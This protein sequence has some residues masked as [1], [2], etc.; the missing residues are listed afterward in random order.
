MGYLDKTGLTY[1]WGKIKAYIS[2]LTANDVGAI[3]KPSSASSGQFLVF[4]GTE[5]VA[6]TL[7]SWQG[8][9]Y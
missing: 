9:S 3:A 2:G 8:G 6:Q 5:W 7:Q 1:F 4:N